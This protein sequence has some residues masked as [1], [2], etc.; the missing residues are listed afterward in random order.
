LITYLVYDRSRNQP[1]PDEEVLFVG[2]ENGFSVVTQPPT[3]EPLTPKQSVRHGFWWTGYIWAIVF[4]AIFITTGWALIKEFGTPPEFTVAAICPDEFVYTQEG[5]AAFEKETDNWVK[6]YLE[7]N[8]FASLEEL[9]AARNKSWAETGC[10][11]ALK[12][13]QEMEVSDS[14]AIICPT[15]GSFSE[16]WNTWSEGFLA[17]N[18]G[19]GGEKQIKEW[20]ELMIGIGCP[21]WLHP[22]KNAI[23]GNCEADGSWSSSTSG[24]I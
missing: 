11:E 19:S 3:P 9:T 23:C 14:E 10:T 8:P 24:T 13:Y 12:A 15:N 4:S 2:E 17:E 6:L 20:N 16:I 5:S 7:S 18:P 1:V 21:A 22:L